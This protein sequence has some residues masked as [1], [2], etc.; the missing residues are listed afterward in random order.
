MQTI[1]ICSTNINH[2]TRWADHAGQIKHIVTAFYFIPQ[3]VAKCEASG[4]KSTPNKL[5]L[6]FN[7]LS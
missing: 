5:K 2:F 1:L 4:G 3:I 6:V 7:T